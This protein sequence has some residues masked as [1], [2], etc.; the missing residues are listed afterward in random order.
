MWL[1][2][3]AR[4]AL[5]NQSELNERIGKLAIVEGPSGTR[6]L[7]RFVDAAEGTATFHVSGVVNGYPT[8]DVCDCGGEV[9][10]ERGAL[11]WNAPLT[12]RTRD[13][14][15]RDFRAVRLFTRTV[16]PNGER[17][18]G[19]FVRV[20]EECGCEKHKEGR[21]SQGYGCEHVALDYSGAGGGEEMRPASTERGERRDYYTLTRQALLRQLETDRG[22]LEDFRRLRAEAVREG[23][24]TLATDRARNVRGF[25]LVVEALEDA[26]VKL[27]TWAVDALVSNCPDCGSGQG[28]PGTHETS[29][30]RKLE[31]VTS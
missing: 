25:L 12:L 30:P 5:M 9:L 10:R 26:L 19:V 27:D 15:V 24:G 23:K 28:L 29:C 20:G 8:P 16:F 17:A 22:E 21:A 14:E 31:G 6:Y 3:G 7:A 18:S 11:A 2:R 1:L 13:V 4:G